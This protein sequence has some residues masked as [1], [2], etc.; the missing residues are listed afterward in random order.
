M[1]KIDETM[2]LA[3]PY[4]WSADIVFPDSVQEEI[5]KLLVCAATAHREGI[6]M[7][8][9][10]VG[11]DAD[12]NITFLDCM[13]CPPDLLPSWVMM[14]A[15][16][17]NWVVAI[18]CTEGWTIPEEARRDYGK[19]GGY[20]GELKDHPEAY[21]VLIVNVETL[22][23]TWGGQAKIVGEDS[24]RTVKDELVLAKADEA[25][26]LLNNLLKPNWSKDPIGTLLRHLKAKLYYDKEPADESDNTDESK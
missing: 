4:G 18:M 15:D 6:E 10:F 16:K 11:L 5:R 12:N 8:T 1:T 26:G 2:K 9:V 24:N 13:G 19:P 21:E 20:M 25:T 17:N 7:H 23:G 3:E 14:Q 22:Q